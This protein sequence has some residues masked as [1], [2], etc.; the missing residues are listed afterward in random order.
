MQIKD[1]SFVHITKGQTII[2][3]YTEWCGHC[4]KITPMWNDL[5]TEMSDTELVVAAVEADSEKNNPGSQ[6]AKVFPTILFVVRGQVVGV[7]KGEYSLHSFKTYAQTMMQ[8]GTDFEDKKLQQVMVDL[9]REKDELAGE[10]GGGGDSSEAIEKVGGKKRK[11]AVEEFE[12]I[13]NGLTDANYFAKT[14]ARQHLL[15]VYAEWCSKSKKAM[16]VIADLSQHQEMLPAG[17]R[18]ARLKGSRYKVTLRMLHLQGYCY[19]PFE[20]SP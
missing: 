17:V 5:S 13:V 7:Y 11:M 1:E 12:E 4:K 16:P 14:T 2:M 19:P 10:N 20:G 6:Y 15:F 3:Y 18:V 9:S 8:L